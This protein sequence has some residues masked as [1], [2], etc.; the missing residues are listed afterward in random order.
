MEPGEAMGNR[1]DLRT[2]WRR[3]GGGGSP[4]GGEQ[5]AAQSEGVDRRLRRA[6]WLRGKKKTPNALSPKGPICHATDGAIE[7]PTAA[8]TCDA[9]PRGN[10]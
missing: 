5:V 4:G 1:D 2:G 3:C 9:T 8:E 7:H 6:N 10:A